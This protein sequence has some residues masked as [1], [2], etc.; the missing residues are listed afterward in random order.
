MAEIE[1]LAEAARQREQEA[2]W[3]DAAELW[4]ECIWR[5]A[6]HED[7]PLWCAAYG[8]ALLEGGRTLHAISVLRRA[9]MLY[10]DT[11]DCRSTLALAYARAEAP[12]LAAPI[13]AE[14][15]A[16]FTTHADRRWWLPASAYGQLELGQLE[17]AEQAGLKTI[18]E[19]PEA[20]GGHAVLSVIAE[21]RF[22]WAQA[23]EHVER[24]LKVCSASEYTGLMVSKLRILGEMGAAKDC[25]T[26]LE[27]ELRRSPDHPQLL[28]AAAE[29]ATRQGPLADASQRWDSCIAQSPDAPEGYLGKSA[30]QRATGEPAAAAALLRQACDRWPTRISLRQ[31]LAETCAQLRDMEEAR[32]QWAMAERLGPLS[33]FRL[34]AQCAFLGSIGADDEAEAMLARREASGRVLWRGRFEYAK[35]ARELDRSL[36]CLED[37]TSASPTEAVLVL[38]DAEI[39]SWRQDVGD[40]EK[41]AASLR[42]ILAQSPAAVRVAELLARVLVL[43]GE[44]A[45]AVRLVAGIPAADTRRS[46]GELRLWSDVHH[47]D[48]RG[49][50]TRW[51]KIASDFF[52]PALHLRKAELRAVGSK[53]KPA[54]SRGLLAISVLRNERPRLQGFL[55]HHRG[56]G[57]DGFVLIDNGSSD[58]STEFLAAQPDVLLY[59]TDDSYAQSQYGARWLNQLLDLHG[60]GWVVYADADERLVFPGSESRPLSDL[61]GYMSGR[62]EQVLP[63]VMIDM[64]PRHAGQSGPVVHDWFD[65]LRIRASVQCPFIEAAGGARRRLFGTTVTLSKAPLIDAGAG[66]RYLTSHATTPARVSAVTAGLLHY[67][68]DYLFDPSNVQRLKDEVARAEHSDHAVDR[69]RSL[70]IMHALSGADLKGPHSQRYKNSAQLL[71]LGLIATTKEFEEGSG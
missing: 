10:P 54:S 62:G 13:W 29:L 27:D 41:A 9:V 53:F 35:A 17:L 3:Q 61:V 24:A 46:T 52:M 65:P 68:L 59:A 20:T 47:G 12:D 2:A 70:A 38:A 11:A 57:V 33:I 4:R 55:D 7:R 42:A 51:K 32:R 37:M 64:F 15:L 43:L 18:A 23:L 28:A 56:L 21:R 5:S 48:W 34:W 16:N 50:A 30:L 40:L 6:E 25:A 67:H 1:A 26:I 36:A 8:R 63:G 22:R 45:D 69:R 58:G 39:R 44:P 19:Y 71:R 66:V 49:A 31:A 60:K 14:L